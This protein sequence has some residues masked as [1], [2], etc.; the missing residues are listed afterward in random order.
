MLSLMLLCL[1]LAA[2][3]IPTPS[4]AVVRLR[5]LGSPTGMSRSRPFVARWVLGQRRGVLL[6]LCVA[7]GG[8]VG[9]AGCLAVVGRAQSALVGGLAGSLL[10]AVVGQVGRDEVDSRRGGQADVA[11]G[12][13]VGC[14]AE[15]LRSG[16][17]PASALSTAATV[18][19]VPE[20]AEL[21]T[22]VAAVA[23]AGG[24]VPSALRAGAG[25]ATGRSASRGIDRLAAGWAVSERS[26]ASLAA[27][28]DRI[29]DDLAANRRQ[30]QQVAAQLAGPR[31]TA[32][33]LAFLPVLGVLLGT[34]TGARPLA[35]L[36]GTP[37]G[38]L[39]LLLGVSLHAVGAVWTMKIVRAAG[40]GR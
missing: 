12:L 37:A 27:V 29:E 18:A 22:E 9:V 39:L 11:L 10:G 36:F 16:Q 3:V 30:R 21:F 20:I 38:Q 17:R 15:E 33:L 13:A 7:G 26:G 6:M 2:A 25:S 35:V 1:G 32:I 19:A 34:A 24:D 14:L 40:G 8:T 28:L 23:S 5:S 4:S 31:A